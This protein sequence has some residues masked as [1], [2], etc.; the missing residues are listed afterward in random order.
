MR[1]HDRGC[2][3]LACGAALSVVLSCGEPPDDGGGGLRDLP[4]IQWSGSY[5]E[6]GSDVDVEVCPATL[7]SEDE[8]ME[9]VDEYV[10]SNTT[11]P[12]GY[13]RLGE[14]L[15]DYGFSCPEGSYGCIGHDDERLVIG[16]KLLIHRHELIHASSPT[17]T[18]RLLEEGLAVFMGTDLKWAGIAEP[19][20]IRAALDSVDGV[21]GILPPEFYPV[22]GHFV[23]FL[24]EE[25]GLPAVVSLVEASE[26]G[27][28]LD[29]LGEL[30]VE[31]LGRDLRLEIDAYEAAGPGCEVAQ[32]SP[33]WF[34]CELAPPSIPIFACNSE[35]YIMVDVSVTCA[36][37]ASGVQDGMIWRDVLIDSPGRDPVII[38][39]YEGDPVEFIVRS[40]GQGCST[41][42]THVDSRT[43]TE[44]ALPQGVELRE[45]L[46]LVRI[47]KPVEAQGRVRFS[48]VPSCP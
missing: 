35:G 30:S 4:P 8:Y 7:P 46:N 31:H 47:I 10:R 5:I 37:G 13:Y 26:P 42:F 3:A 29:E 22:A 2:R 27:M 39:L 43:A 45:G 11:F 17:S 44:P 41:S 32:Y 36:D 33:T 20:E 19:L 1:H 34:Q 9:G 12:I 23:S 16:S 48:V 38:G 6:F 21:P 40:C 25:H 14:D 28:T 24:V 15:T 18:H